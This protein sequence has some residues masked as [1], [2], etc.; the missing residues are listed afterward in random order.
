MMMRLGK[1]RLRW[2][3]IPLGVALAAT[4]L[5]ATTFDRPITMNAMTN[6]ATSIFPGRVVSK[7]SYRD[8]TRGYVMTRVI[9]ECTEPGVKGSLGDQVGRRTIVTMIGG[10]RDGIRTTVPGNPSI[11]V[12]QRA[13]FF[14]E[15][16]PA[17]VVVFTGLGHGVVDIE[18]D[19]AAGQDVVDVRW[20][21]ETYGKATVGDL[22][23][24]AET[25]RRSLTTFLEDI[26]EV[27]R[28]EEDRAREKAEHEQ[29]LRESQ[30]KEEGGR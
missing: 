26:K 16:K 1:L 12:G 5:P 4:L 15:E 29:R 22:A 10:S 30:Q 9:V 24:N 2:M 8:Q 13:V 11:R 23:R 3:M 25:G 17:G 6:W 14:L 20:P 19:A 18:H 21:V 27:V 28:L 7:D